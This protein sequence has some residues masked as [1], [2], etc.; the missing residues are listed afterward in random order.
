VHV[1]KSIETGLHRF[2]QVCTHLRDAKT[3]SSHFISVFLQN[4]ACVVA[5]ASLNRERTVGPFS[6]HLGEKAH[7]SHQTAT[8]SRALKSMAQ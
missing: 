6:N 8:E 2:A 7:G 5:V 4:Q 1:D 3:N